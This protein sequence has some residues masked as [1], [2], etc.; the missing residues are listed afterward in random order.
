MF[1]LL[2]CSSYC[3]ERTAELVGVSVEQL[4]AP[5]PVR[6]VSLDWAVESGNVALVDSLL[7]SRVNPKEP[8]ISVGTSLDVSPVALASRAGHEAVV[9]RLLEEPSIDVNSSA[10]NEEVVALNGETPLHWAVHGR[11]PAYVRTVKALCEDTRTAVDATTSTGM[12]PLM[13]AAKSEWANACE[14]AQELLSAHAD[15]NRYATFCEPMRL[16]AMTLAIVSGRSDVLG[17]LLDSGQIQIDECFHFGKPTLESYLHVAITARM[18]DMVL[19]LLECQALTDF[20]AAAEC[21]PVKLAVDT[22]SV[23]C[24]YHLL[25]RGADTTDLFSALYRAQLLGDAAGVQDLVLSMEATPDDVVP[26]LHAVTLYADVAR[27]KQDI[28]ALGDK[29]K[30]MLD[31]GSLPAAYYA[32]ELG[33]DNIARVL[34]IEAHGLPPRAV[35]LAIAVTNVTPAPM[36]PYMPGMRTYL[37]AKALLTPI[38]ATCGT[39]ALA[40]GVLS[41]FLPWCGSA[42]ALDF[43]TTQPVHFFDMCTLCSIRCQELCASIDGAISR[44]VLDKLADIKSEDSTEPVMQDSAGLL[45]EL[46]WGPHGDPFDME[47]CCNLEVYATR[48][49]AVLA[50][51]LDDIF[52]EDIRSTLKP[53]DIQEIVPAPPKTFQRMMNKMFSPAEHGSHTFTRPRCMRDLDVLRLSVSVRD[54]ASME[55]IIEN[56]RARYDIVRVTNNHEPKGAFSGVRHTSVYFAYDSKV[57]FRDLFGC[58]PAASSEDGGSPDAGAGGELGACQ[59]GRI[60]RDYMSLFGDTPDTE[61]CMEPLWRIASLRREATVVLVGELQ[62]LMEPY[63]ERWELLNHLYKISRCQTPAELVRRYAPVR[64]KRWGTEEYRT[65]RLAA[66][67]ARSVRDSYH[68]EFLEVFLPVETHRMDDL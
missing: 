55:Q 46:E 30:H 14:I 57:L 25:L 45:P 20:P 24:V 17:A 38:A 50:F 10:K 32:V 65:V 68:S 19:L 66:G 56:V 61:R 12:T 34:L 47:E 41:F 15:A 31:G 4:D 1:R 64:L 40:E 58:N 63:A 59:R 6:G 62:I 49:L 36:N 54:A 28:S 43:F 33:F 21:S 42:A 48:A 52:Q 2:N 3:C 37:A 5:R 27:V 7:K 39:R 44:P 13:L 8:L 9:A 51:A 18:S 16:S 35:E 22:Q 26:S 53:L 29:A 67:L 11:G 60:W 23:E